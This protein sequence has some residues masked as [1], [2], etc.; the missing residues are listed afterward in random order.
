MCTGHMDL[1]LFCILSTNHCIGFQGSGLLNLWHDEFL[2]C[3]G[4]RLYFC[5]P[6]EQLIGYWGLLFSWPRSFFCWLFHNY[7]ACYLTVRR[8]VAFADPDRREGMA[9]FLRSR[10]T[11]KFSFW[12]LGDPAANHNITWML[13]CF[14]HVW[15]GRK[16]AKTM[17][18][19]CNIPAC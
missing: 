14:S 16:P 9:W 2:A 19:K 17:T 8:Y 4:P 5:L 3:V 13:I 15:L 10:R 1:F 11:V 18:S 7:P 12:L 6:Q